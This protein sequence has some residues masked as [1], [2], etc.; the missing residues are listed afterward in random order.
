MPYTLPDARSRLTQYARNQTGFGSQNRDPNDTEWAD[1]GRRVGYSGSGDLSDEQFSNAQLEI[2]RQ[3]G[4][5]AQPAGNTTTGNTTGGYTLA[6][7]Q[8]R[9]NNYAR[10][11]TRFGGQNRD[12]NQAEWTEL[13]RRVGYTGG[14]ISDDLYRR[15]EQEIGNYYGLNAPTTTP[16][17]TGNTTPPTTPGNISAGVTQPGATGSQNYPGGGPWNG[18][19]WQDLLQALTNRP[20][21][22]PSALQTQADA[23]LGQLLGQ[24][25]QPV[26]ITDPSLAGASNAFRAASE[27]GL[28][29]ARNIAAERANAGGTLNSGNFDNTVQSLAA[30]TD[31]GIAANDAA[32]V[33]GETEQRR[34]ALLQALGLA[35]T[36]AQGQRG[37][38][39]QEMFGV[40]DMALG[41]RGQDLQGALGFGNLDLQRVLGMG[42][43]DLRRLLGQQQYGLG[44]GALGIDL[45]NSLMQNDQFY[46]SL[47][48]NASQFLQNQN[49][50]AM[51]LLGNLFR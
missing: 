38:E 35:N 36:S 24:L 22:P 13:A 18:G 3:Y 28:E 41:G 14:N 9:L 11:Q 30:A 15:A 21:L 5:A 19:N 46:S 1:L 45:L 50:T 40:G 8:S 12:L 32:L 25:G 34:Q 7:A 2:A 29:R 26:S 4:P 23:G 27:R 16:P 6:D 49:N 37:Q 39:L 47:G 48:L 43:L 51:T 44:R 33:Q 31:Q 10:T 42:D 17:P 20:R